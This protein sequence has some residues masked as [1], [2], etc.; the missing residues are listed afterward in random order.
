MARISQNLGIKE[1]PES[2]QKEIGV[3]NGSLSFHKR[4][5][6]G[7]VQHETDWIFGWDSGR[8]IRLAKEWEIPFLQFF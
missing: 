7:T 4:E 5:C 6:G 1:F 8:Q 3:Y 2:G